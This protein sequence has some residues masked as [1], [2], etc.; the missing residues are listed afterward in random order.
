[1]PELKQLG[2]LT[3]FGGNG[4]KVVLNYPIRSNKISRVNGLV[5]QCGEG[6]EPGYAT[7]THKE[8][9]VDL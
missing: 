5:L 3:G 4:K 8:W 1:V 6:N 2:L 7:I 9:A